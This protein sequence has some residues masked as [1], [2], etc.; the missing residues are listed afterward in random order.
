LLFTVFLIYQN[1]SCFPLK[2][3]INLQAKENINEE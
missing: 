3:N 2:A 1:K